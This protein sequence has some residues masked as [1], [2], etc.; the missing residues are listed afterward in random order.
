MVQGDI[1]LRQNEKKP[2]NDKQ[3]IMLNDKISAIEFGQDNEYFYLG[4][5]RG[6]IRK[7]ELPSPI[8]AKDLNEYPIA[9]GEEAPEAKMV[10]DSS[11]FSISAV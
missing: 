5:E 1:N 6:L 10:A 8:Q 3:K 2:R 11:N 9:S 4:T 7:Y